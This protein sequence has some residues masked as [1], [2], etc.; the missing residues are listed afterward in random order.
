MT[1]FIPPNG[2]EERLKNLESQLSLDKPTPKT[3]YKR[4]KMLEDRL[5]LLESISPE[6]IQFWVILSCI[7][8]NVTIIITSL[9]QDKTNLPHKSVKKKVFSLKEIDELI[10]EVEKKNS[11]FQ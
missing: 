7:Q 5:L 2:I 9:F 3:I 10:S 4:L 1:K 6:Y 8:Q 11:K